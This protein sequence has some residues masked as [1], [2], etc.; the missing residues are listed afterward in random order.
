MLLVPPLVC[1]AMVSAASR[2]DL[3]PAR[4]CREPEVHGERVA[5]RECPARRRADHLLRM[6]RA[7]GRTQRCRHRGTSPRW[8]VRRS[9]HAASCWSPVFSMNEAVADLAAECDLRDL[10]PRRSDQWLQVHGERRGR[11]AR[12][13]API[14]PPTASTDSPKEAGDPAPC[15]ETLGHAALLRSVQRDRP[16]PHGRLLT[17]FSG[18]S[19]FV[20]RRRSQREPANAASLREPNHSLTS[21]STGFTV[22]L[23]AKRHAWGPRATRRQT[24]SRARAHE[25]K[26]R[27]ARRRGARATAAPGAPGHP[28]GAEGA[29]DRHGGDRRRLVEEAWRRGRRNPR[30]RSAREPRTAARRAGRPPRSGRRRRAP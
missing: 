16:Y 8:L 2:R 11:V 29:E 9:T 28:A 13:A 22:E 20:S 4:R 30:A 21:L 12:G 18:S 14:S 27:R 3:R 19:A 25:L 1:A 24:S 17:P 5:R 23:F 10:V 7:S 15:A 26:M 6:S